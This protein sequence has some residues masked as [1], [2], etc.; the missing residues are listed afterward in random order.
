MTCRGKQYKEN[1]VFEENVNPET[2]ERGMHFCPMPL[3]VLNYYSPIGSEFAEVE[4]L[5]DVAKSD[6]KIATNKLKIGAKVSFSGLFK[7]QF[8][9]IREKIE[10][11]KKDSSTTGYRSHSSTT[12]YSSH[13][14]TTGEQS[15]SC[16]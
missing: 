13:S 12:G 9:I 3:D 6:N 16:S 1:E 8:D 14:S 4:A 10:A 7:A 2:C 5:G 11:S 15:I